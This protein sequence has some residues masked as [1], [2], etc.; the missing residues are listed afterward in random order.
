MF[1]IALQPSCMQPVMKGVYHFFRLSTTLVFSH[2]EGFI[3]QLDS[4][5]REVHYLQLRDVSDRIPKLAIELY[6]KR[7]NFREYT[8]QLNIIIQW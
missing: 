6:E 2:I 1:L 5:L 3:F 4:I 7:D 8:V